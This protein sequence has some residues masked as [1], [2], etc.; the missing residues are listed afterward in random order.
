[1]THPKY[2]SI[3]ELLATAE[4]LDTTEHHSDW[5][6][7][8]HEQIQ[9]FADATDD[10][11]WIHVDPARAANGPFGAP[12]AHGFLTLSLL[13]VLLRDALVVDGCEMRV[14][15]GLDRVRFTSP[16]RAGA[17][18]RAVSNL[19]RVEPAAGGAKAVLSVRVEIEGEERPAL[20]AEQIVLLV[21]AAT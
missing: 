3:D 15:Y 7:I 9:A 12:I 14:N 16:V 5:F 19:A 18:I 1:M 21:R 8:S 10:H 11:Q 17:R 2:A 20:V 4:L 6:S 13:T